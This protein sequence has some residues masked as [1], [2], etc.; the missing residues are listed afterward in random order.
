MHGVPVPFKELPTEMLSLET[1][2]KT[3]IF[4]VN[5]QT[6][7]SAAPPPPPWPGSK[8]LTS[9]SLAPNSLTVLSELQEYSP[10]QGDVW[11]GNPVRREPSYSCLNNEQPPQTASRNYCRV[12][13][14]HLA[15]FG[16]KALSAG[17]GGGDVGMF[18]V[19]AGIGS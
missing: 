4:K 2:W 13:N 11:N 1:L 8:I 10:S 5:R 7:H 18:L 17:S 3:L 14:A 15:L 9:P 19:A 16:Q 6:F 12:Q